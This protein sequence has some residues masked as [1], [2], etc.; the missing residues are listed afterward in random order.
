MAQRKLKHEREMEE[1]LC[2]EYAMHKLDERYN[3]TSMPPR[4]EIGCLVSYHQDQKTKKGLKHLIDQGLIII[5]EEA[6]SSLRRGYF[7][8]VS[9]KIEAILPEYDQPYIDFK[10]EGA[11]SSGKPMYSIYGHFLSVFALRNLG[12]VVHVYLHP[13]E[14]E[15]HRGSNDFCTLSFYPKKLIPELE[16][17]LHR[18]Y[19][20]TLL[21][22]YPHEV[23]GKKFKIRFRAVSGKTEPKSEQWDMFDIPDKFKNIN[24]ESDYTFDRVVRDAEKQ[25]RF[26]SRLVKELKLIRKK[27]SGLSKEERTERLLK[28]SAEYMEHIAPVWGAE[29]KS[30]RLPESEHRFRKRVTE[31]VFKGFR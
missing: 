16:K 23:I 8:F 25:A 17:N 20:A 18:A 31:I 26:F 30:R 24:I 7:E 9:E 13:E 28:W 2:S 11:D 14:Y 12:G 4:K 29:E 22:H 21:E 3:G 6:K 19:V 10:T 1:K 15:M 5:V 27:L